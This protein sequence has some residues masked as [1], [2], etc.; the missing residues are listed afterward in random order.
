LPAIRPAAVAG[1]FYSAD[2]AELRSEIDDL[3]GSIVS[4]ATAPIP[5]ALIAPHAGYIYSGPIAAA[6]YRRLAPARE[7]IMRVVLLGPSHFVGFEAALPLAVIGAN[8]VNLLGQCTLDVGF[9]GIAE[10]AVFTPEDFLT[11]KPI[12]RD[13]QFPY[14]GSVILRKWAN[15]DFGAQVDLLPTPALQAAH[16]RYRAPLGRSNRILLGRRGASPK[17]KRHEMPSH[18][19]LEAFID[20]YLAV[21]GIREDGK[22]PVFRSA[23]GKTGVLTDKPMNRIDVYRMVRRRTA[24][25]GFKVKLGCHVFRATGITAY[26]ANSGALELKSGLSGRPTYHRQAWSRS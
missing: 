9:K 20:E 3:L 25:A 4:A 2:A 15:C 22:T 16:H 8:P 26:L 23:I 24:D 11:E 7:R 13:E 19:K 21:A 14:L 6:G 10:V 1:L 17:P 18:H 12:D 5:K